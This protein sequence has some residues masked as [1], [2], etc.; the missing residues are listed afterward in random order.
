MLLKAQKGRGKKIHLLLDDEYRIT[1][2]AEYWTLHGLP[3]GTDLTEEAWQALVRE[4]EQNKALNKCYDLLSRRD[5]SKKELETKLLRTVSAENARYAVEQMEE[6]GYLDDEKY[7]RKLCDYLLHTKNLSR[8]HL[9]AEMAKRG[10]SREVICQVLEEVEI[11]PVEQILTLLQT[12]FAAK[13]QAENGK[14]KVTAALLRK[15]FSY[16]DVKSAFYR[17]ET[18]DYAI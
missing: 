6:K 1:T 9:T 16:A 15:G 11:D 3:D 17:L 13:L 18:E 4:I 8:R 2:D 12:K 10:L 5:H 7:A 14:Q